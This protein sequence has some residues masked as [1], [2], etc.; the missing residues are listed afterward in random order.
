MKLAAGEDD[1]RE[2]YRVFQ[3]YEDDYGCEEKSENDRGKVIVILKSSSGNELSVKQEDVWL[4]EQEIKEGDEV[5][6]A[7]GKL[8]RRLGQDWTEK[9]NRKMDV[10][11]FIRLMDKL[12]DG[13]TA[14]CP[15]CGGTVSMTEEG[16]GSYRFACD[17][18]DMYFVTA[19]K[20]NTETG[21]R[22]YG[23]D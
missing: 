6:L 18:C 17:S 7:E 10:S 20:E 23:A 11:G 1:M 22:S 21:G 19:C 8:W 12:K 5:F 4:Y 9:W 2:K 3:I 16:T 13:G 15:F 14:L